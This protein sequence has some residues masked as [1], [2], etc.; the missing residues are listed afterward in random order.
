VEFIA[1]SSSLGAELPHCVTPKEYTKWTTES[2][3]VVVEQL[4]IKLL[5]AT[6]RQE[7]D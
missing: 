2:V 1:A 7:G 3:S 4:A 6:G 5:A